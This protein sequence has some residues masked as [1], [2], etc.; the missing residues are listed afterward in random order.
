MEIGF[1]IVLR[2]LD[3]GCIH[4]CILVSQVSMEEIGC[5]SLSVRA[6]LDCFHFSCGSD[7]IDCFHFSWGSDSIDCFHFSWDRDGFDRLHFSWSS[8]SIGSGKIRNGS[9]CWDWDWGWDWSWSSDGE[10]GEGEKSE[11]SCVEKH[12]C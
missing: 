9:F 11:S 1:H 8:D 10:A 6:I 4:H 5:N 12:V 7:C 3:Q 2:R